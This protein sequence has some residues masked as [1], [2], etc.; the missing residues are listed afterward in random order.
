MGIVTLVLAIACANVAGVLLAR[1]SARRREIAVRLA[2][3]AGRGRLIR[4]MLVESSL[5][6]LAGGT[7]GLALA[8][9]MT[10]ALVSLL[11]ALPLPIDVSLPLDARAVGFTLGL[12]LVAAVLSGLAPAF[13][14]SRAEVV[15]GLKS[16]AQGGPERLRL[17][18]AF[19]VSQVAFSIVL[20]VGAGLFARALQRAGDD[21]PRLRSARRRAG[22]G[23]SLAERLH[24]DTTG[25][26]FAH[27]AR[28]ARARAARRPPARRCRR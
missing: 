21:R 8:R 20:V 19:V 10:T 4:Q 5:L 18:N 2:I 26:V 17:R 28:R 11:P 22:D 12:S 24:R 13:H 7:A 23:G 6:F 16:D 27:A 15:G 25:P 1:A 14:A 9:V 3:G